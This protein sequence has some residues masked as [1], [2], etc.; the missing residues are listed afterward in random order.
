MEQQ[1][2]PAHVALAY[3]AHVWIA[4]TSAEREMR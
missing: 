2:F 4:Q 3:H 1:Y